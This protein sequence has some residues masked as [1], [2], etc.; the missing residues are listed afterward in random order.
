MVTYV[1]PGVYKEER[2]PEPTATLQ[3]GVPAFLGY[4]R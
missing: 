2:F 4:T 1:T 3:T